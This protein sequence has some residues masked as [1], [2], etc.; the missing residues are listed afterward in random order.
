MSIYLRA[1]K[2][3][4]ILGRRDFL[5]NPSGVFIRHEWRGL[6]DGSDRTLGVGGT[7]AT[8]AM[9]NTATGLRAA[10]CTSKTSWRDI[11]KMVT[12]IIATRRSWLVRGS[13]KMGSTC[14]VD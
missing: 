13:V 11:G 14:R 10:W 12:E 2:F 1:E 6:Y 4:Q 9:V 5:S 7:A 3:P 8:G